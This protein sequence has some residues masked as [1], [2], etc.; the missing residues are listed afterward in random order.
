MNKRS[1][2]SYLIII[3]FGSLFCFIPISTHAQSGNYIK[4][5][6][7]FCSFTFFRP[8]KTE[9]P[10]FGDVIGYGGFMEV[11]SDSGFSLNMMLGIYNETALITSSMRYYFSTKIETLFFGVGLLITRGQN[12]FFPECGIK[13]FVLKDYIPLIFLFRYSF[14]DGYVTF[15]IGI[16]VSANK[17]SKK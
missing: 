9:N 12:N 10:D 17:K 14:P 2:K 16:G 1:I 11:F 15:S 6:P 5:T 8:L 4:V 3:V 7:G 13:L